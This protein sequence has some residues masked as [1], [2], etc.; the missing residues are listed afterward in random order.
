MI[1]MS[2]TEPSQHDGSNMVKRKRSCVDF[3]SRVGSLQNG[4][5]I[6]VKKKNV[7]KIFP[8][9]AQARGGWVQPFCNAFELHCHFVVEKKAIL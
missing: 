8:K 9:F 3:L 7:D 5:I 1:S 6:F 2:L 4:S